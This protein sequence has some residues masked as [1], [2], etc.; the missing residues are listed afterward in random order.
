MWTLLF[1]WPARVQ[2]QICLVWNHQHWLHPA[3]TGDPTP[4]LPMPAKIQ[5]YQSQTWCCSLVPPVSLCSALESPSAWTHGISFFGGFLFSICQCHI[6]RL[7]FLKSFQEPKTELIKW[8]PLNSNVSIRSKSTS[9][10]PISYLS[11]NMFLQMS[12]YKHEWVQRQQCSLRKT[13]S[14]GP[15]LGCPIIWLLLHCLV[16]ILLGSGKSENAVPFFFFTKS[17]AKVQQSLTSSGSRG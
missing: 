5:G 9:F 1:L 8:K 15:Q 7:Q 4:L 13:S 16:V 6:L 2:E 17:T 11:E 3:H 12:A 14:S 10:S